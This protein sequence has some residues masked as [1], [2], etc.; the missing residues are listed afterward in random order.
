MSGTKTPYD[1]LMEFISAG[2]EAEAVS[3]V[4]SLNDEQIETLA[5]DGFP[6]FCENWDDKAIDNAQTAALLALMARL[7]EEAK[8]THVP[9]IVDIDS[10]LK[11]LRSTELAVILSP[12]MSEAQCQDP[13]L[14]INISQLGLT[15]HFDIFYSAKMEDGDFRAFSRFALNFERTAVGLHQ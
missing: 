15:T 8:R 3:Y 13:Q 2:N 10:N 9:E 14:A 12:Y 5:T 11:F 1:G 6:F 7:P 4:N